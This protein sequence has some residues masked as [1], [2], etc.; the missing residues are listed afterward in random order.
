MKRLVA[1]LKFLKKIFILTISI[2]NQKASNCKNGL[3]SLENSYVKKE[4]HIAS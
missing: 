2:I 4:K 3:S 1:G